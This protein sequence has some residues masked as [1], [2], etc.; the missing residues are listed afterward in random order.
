L[1]NSE[2]QIDK[3]GKPKEK[4]CKSMRSMNSEKKNVSVVFSNG[5]SRKKKFVTTDTG[6]LIM[7]L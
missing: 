7:T 3:R 5:F 2:I 1:R 4:H 6:K